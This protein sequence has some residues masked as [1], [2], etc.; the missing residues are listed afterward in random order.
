MENIK[1]YLMYLRKSRNDSD[2]ETVEDI[3]AR[4]ETIL[5][6]YAYKKF[7][8]YMPEENIFREIV[9]G[10]TIDA[11]PQIRKIL[12]LTANNNYD[13][14]I[15]VE[16]QRLT[17]GDMLDCGT[18]IRVFRYNN[19]KII[20]PDCTYDL[21]NAQERKYLE[22]I[23]M[24][25]NDYLEYIKTI[26]GR[27]R[28]SSVK[29]GCY[30]GSKPPFGYDKTI[31]D[32]KHTLTPNNDA[33]AVKLIFD[34]FVN[35]DLGSHLI[36]LE[37]ERRG[38]HP[39]NAVLWHPATIRNILQNPVYA[40]KIRWNNKKLI[41]VTDEYGNTKEKRDCKS[42]DKLIT[43]GLHQA[44][45]PIDLFEKAQNKFGNMPR[46]SVDKETVNPFASLIKCG[47]CGKSYLLKKSTKNENSRLKCS[48]QIHCR[49]SSVKYEPIKNAIIKT[50]LACIDN[51]EV[52]INNDDSGSA[53]IQKNIL[54]KL[55]NEYRQLCEQQTKLYELIEKGIYSQ[56]LFLER[57]AI[58]SKN[59]TKLE[60]A[61]C[62]QEGNLP[63][64]IDY[65]K[66]T[67]DI[68]T[69]IKMINNKNIPAKYKNT[70]LKSIIKKIELTSPLLQT[71]NQNNTD[72]IKMNIIFK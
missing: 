36:A 28:L 49:C 37:L 55:K 51:Y 54:K 67:L 72:N 42:Q 57:Q 9:S 26:L 38:L 5:Q 29:E 30:I 45:I 2:S 44:I 34:L 16:P 46:T 3:L 56:S 17:R 20:T 59:K 24:Q 60:K 32:N 18:I 6:E 53:E 64:A 69:A 63:A 14:V 1:K 70:F 7:G 66:R 21:N 35:Q 61:I 8:Y 33:D 50:L 71:D 13:G 31:I 39:L 15:V 58:L 43:D 41:K 11:R 23:L 68:H 65:K 25:G 27:G 22:M 47:R 40:G 19:I 62:E 48:N 4:H 52:E 12:S 10:E